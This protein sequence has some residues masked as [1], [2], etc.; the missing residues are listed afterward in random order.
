[1]LA[2]D[3]YGVRA[4]SSAGEHYVDIVGVTGS[5][6]V[7]H[8]IPFN[9]LL[10]EF[11]LEAQRGVRRA[12]AVRCASVL[13]GSPASGTDRAAATVSPGVAFFLLGRFA[14]LAVLSSMV[15]R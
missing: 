3:R 13:A 4:R 7:A 14:V 5:I 9:R 8:T 6:P 10:A 2:L 1:M 11:H 15:R 12:W